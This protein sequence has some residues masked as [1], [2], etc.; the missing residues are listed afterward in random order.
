MKHLLCARH[1]TIITF[2]PQ[3]PW[4]SVALIIPILQI[5]KLRLTKV[6]WLV[7]SQTATRYLS[8][9]LNTGLP[10]SKV[11]C[12]IHYISKLPTLLNSL[13]LFVHPSISKMLVPKLKVNYELIL[14]SYLG[15]D[16][17]AHQ[18]S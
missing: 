4:E 5:R 7:Q 10:V 14:Y 8:P 6:K 1:F 15:F 11:W 3:T 9:H 17:C 2:P 16:L 13:K 18:I 12:S